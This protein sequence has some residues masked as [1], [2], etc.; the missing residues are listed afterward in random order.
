M[1]LQPLF[2][3]FQRYFAVFRAAW[4][5]ERVAGYKHEL[6]FLPAALELQETPPHPA[7]S[8]TLDRV[9][10]DQLFLI[11]ADLGLSWAD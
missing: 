3:L 8:S 4:Q 5:L 11:S 7:P 2:A 6:A 9:G 10:F 1:F